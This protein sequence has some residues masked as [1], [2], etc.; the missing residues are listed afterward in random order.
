M[1]SKSTSRWRRA[2]WLLPVLGTALVC[3]ACG[4]DDGRVPV[5]PVHGQVFLD[6]KAVPHAYVVFHPVGGSAQSDIHPRA[7][8]EEDGSFWLSTYDSGDGAPVGDYVITV[9]AYKAQTESDNGNSPNLLPMPYA[10]PKTS[11]LRAHVEASEN[12]LSALQLKR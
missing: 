8:A 6:G 10:N 9:Q 5:F 12:E 2:A 11:K 4:R 7:H 3:S 1:V